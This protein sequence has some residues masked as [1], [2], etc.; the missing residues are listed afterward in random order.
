MDP[1]QHSSCFI[2]FSYSDHA[3]A[4]RLHA[5]L[6]DAGVRVWFSPKDIRGGEKL[7][8]QVSGA[9]QS[10]DRLLLI[11]SKKSMQSEW[12]KTEIRRALLAEGK[13]ERRKIF[14]IRLCSMEALRDWTCFDADTGNDMAVRIREYFIPDFS[15][16]RN[17]EDFARGFSRLLADLSLPC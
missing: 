7:I 4:S 17:R 15:G 13:T 9:I 3:F 1:I 10:H 2:S 16:W 12:V 14:P 8:D 5:R 6:N 11:L